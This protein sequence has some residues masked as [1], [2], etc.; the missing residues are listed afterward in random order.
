MARVK[1]TKVGSEFRVRDEKGK[2]RGEFNSPKKAAKRA[3][4]VARKNK[5]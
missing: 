1:K 5:K 3:S 2:L 4:K